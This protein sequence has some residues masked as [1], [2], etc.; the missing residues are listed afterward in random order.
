MI[1]RIVYREDSGV[2]YPQL[3]HQNR[4][5][6]WFKLK[7]KW[8]TFTLNGAKIGFRDINKAK[9]YIKQKMLEGKETVVWQ[10]NLDEIVEEALVKND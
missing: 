10:S 7:D 6:L 9:S 2:Y 3:F 5:F 8:E 1:T 4:K